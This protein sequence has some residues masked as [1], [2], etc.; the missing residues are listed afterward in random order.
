MGLLSFLLS[1]GTSGGH[2][3]MH[4][5]FFRWSQEGLCKIYDALN[6]LLPQTCV[7]PL[8]Q[9]CVKYILFALYQYTYLL[10]YFVIGIQLETL[11]NS[12]LF[13]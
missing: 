3:K 9:L 5:S 11:N 8:F 4:Y 1:A 2:K 6:T 7:F 13:P 10:T 12:L